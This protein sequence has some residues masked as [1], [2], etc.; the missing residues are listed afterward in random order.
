VKEY[1]AAITERMGGSMAGASQKVEDVIELM[2][3]TYDYMVVTGMR[4]AGAKGLPE[5]I[6]G[7]N[8]EV[9]T[10]RLPRDVILSN[11]GLCIELAILWAS[12]MD[13]LGANP[14]S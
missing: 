6:G 9:Q 7:E 11:N 5:T 12:I 2:K 14:T 8:Q 13:Q 4:Y 10:V 3:A 1:A